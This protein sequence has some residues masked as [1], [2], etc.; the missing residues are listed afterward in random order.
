MSMKFRIFKNMIKQGFQGMWR[1][2]GMGLASVGSITAVLI[3]LGIVLIMVLSINNV[4]IEIKN[5]FDEIQIFLEDDITD[6]QLDYIEEQAKANE[7][8]LSVIYQSKE[9]AMEIMKEDWGENAY[10]LEGLETNPLQ[11]SFIV[12]L[13][14]IEYA[15]SVVN[16]IKELEGIDEVKYYQDVIEKLVLLA[17]YVRGG[18]LIITAI[19]ILVSIFIIS[20]TIKITVTA[21]EREINIMKYVGATNGYIRGPF[22]I[23]GVLFG[24]AG[25]FLSIL[26]VNYGYRYFFNAVNDKLYVL[27]TVYLV[28]PIALMKD[29]SIIF[30]AIGMGIGALGSLLSLKRFLNA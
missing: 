13:K 17:K 29:I 6:E 18:G 20:N 19:L 1:N 5:K 3:I 21:R 28:P 2:R 12:K 7:G 14:G 22:I 23:E 16:K 8:V 30:I 4:V 9:Q 10:L 11:N 25:A 24:L 15:D 27:F 26:I